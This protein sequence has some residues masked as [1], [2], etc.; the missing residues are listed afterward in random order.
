[1]HT[2]I[3]ILLILSYKVQSTPAAICS[4]K[5][6]SNLLQGNFRQPRNFSIVSTYRVWFLYE[7]KGLV[8]LRCLRSQRQC[9]PGSWDLPGQKQL[10]L[11]REPAVLFNSVHPWRLERDAIPAQGYK[12]WRTAEYPRKHNSGWWT[13]YGQDQ[14]FLHRPEPQGF[15][16]TWAE[17]SY[18]SA[19][20]K[21]LYGC[22]LLGKCR[23]C[24]DTEWHRTYSAAF[25]P[26]FSTREWQTSILPV[27]QY[28][29]ERC[30]LLF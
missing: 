9:V 17:I 28:W 30:R 20:F 13:A 6:S 22:V 19:V 29:E 4:F 24:P 15:V 7:S 3:L 2:F 11:H 21:E 1:M 26:F 8:Y 23:H 25:A 14:Q 16:G 5:R 10:L 18:V 27:P 12:G